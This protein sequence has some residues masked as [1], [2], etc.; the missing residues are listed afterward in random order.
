MAVMAELK[1]SVKVDAIVKCF[2]SIELTE[3]SRRQISLCS[4][5]LRKVVRLS[6]QL[7]IVV[8]HLVIISDW[9]IELLP[10]VDENACPPPPIN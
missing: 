2:Y 3:S 10:I 1:R 7:F 5:L 8:I 4:L 6:N 9:K